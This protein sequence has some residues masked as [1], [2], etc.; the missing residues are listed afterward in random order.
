MG[1]PK[2]LIALVW[3][4]IGAQLICNVF[5]DN[6]MYANANISASDNTTEYSITESV[7]L[8]N[9]TASYFSTG[10]EILRFFG[11]LFFFDYTI[12]KNY[13]AITMTTTA[14]DF[15][16]V[17]YLLIGIGTIMF[18]DLLVTLRRLIFG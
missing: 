12:F 16:I 18:I 4:Y 14:N 10:K 15:A 3:L 17:R 7:G 2:L 8:T 1:S 5:E 6:M 13:D 11:K 9:D